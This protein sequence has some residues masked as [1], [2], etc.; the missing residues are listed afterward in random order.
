MIDFEEPKPT[1]G[2]FI[3]VF[4]K[5][6]PELKSFELEKDKNRLVCGLGS[7]FRNFVPAPVSK[8]TILLRLTEEDRLVFL[9]LLKK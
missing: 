2:F 6:S 3:Y 5:Q 8:L 4:A 1:E 9:N 7:L